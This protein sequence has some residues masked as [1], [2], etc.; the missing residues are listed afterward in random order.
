MCTGS[1]GKESRTMEYSLGAHKRF[2]EGNDLSHEAWRKYKNLQ[3]KMA[4]KLLQFRTKNLSDIQEPPFRWCPKVRSPAELLKLA[5]WGSYWGNQEAAESIWGVMTS[6]NLMFWQDYSGFYV[7]NW[8]QDA[9]F[10]RWCLYESVIGLERSRYAWKYSRAKISSNWRLNMHMKRERGVSEFEKQ[11]KD[12]LIYW[13][14]GNSTVCLLWDAYAMCLM[15]EKTSVY[16][17][18]TSTDC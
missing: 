4:G 11:A 9:R 7:E 13:D 10:Q 14:L 1:Y 8:L 15:S 6:S 2:L 12:Q 5:L 17:L 18:P 3:M 16:P